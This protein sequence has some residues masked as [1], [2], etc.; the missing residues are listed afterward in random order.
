MLVARTPTPRKRGRPPLPADQKS[1]AVT[2]WLHSAEYE[3]L[4]AEA[5][6]HGVS[7]SRLVRLRV[8]ASLRALDVEIP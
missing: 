2:T 5:K 1:V 3:A 8:R 6:R 7:L 4:Y